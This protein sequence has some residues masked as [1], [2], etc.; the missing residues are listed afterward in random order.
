[1]GGTLDGLRGSLPIAGGE[2]PDL[3]LLFGTDEERAAEQKKLTDFGNRF[4]AAFK[5][6]DMGNWVPRSEKA[7]KE[8][9][10]QPSA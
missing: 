6:D 10:P 7:V 9:F 1:M 2:G 3:R 5:Q 4:M 8:N